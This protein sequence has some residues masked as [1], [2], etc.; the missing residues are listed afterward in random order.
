MGM[1]IA[2]VDMPPQGIEVTGEGTSPS[3]EQMQ[4]EQ[5]ARQKF[6]DFT[7]PRLEALLSRP[8]RRSGNVTS[9]EL[10]GEGV[11]SK[12]N[13]YL[14]IVTTDIG[15]P[16]LDWTDVVPPG[17]DVSVLAAGEYGSMGRWPDKAAQ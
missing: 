5:A 16:G 10:I 11:W 8:L 15:D 9:V 1:V 13:H 14:V 3:D 7:E 12:L 6:R 17:A 2:S 4:E